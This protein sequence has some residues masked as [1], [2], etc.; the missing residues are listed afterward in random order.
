MVYKVDRLT[1]SLADFAK[2]IEVFD[3]QGASFVAVTQQFNTTSS[4]GRLTLNIL[5]SFAQFERKVTGE[6]IRDKIAASKRQGMWMGGLEPL[7]YKRQGR[8]VII[9]PEEAETVRTIFKLYNDLGFVRR[10]DARLC[11]LEIVSRRRMKADGQ[12]VGGVP[13]S[14]GS[15]YAM[16]SN[17]IYIGQIRHKNVCHAGLHEAIITPD[18]WEATQNLLARNR[19]GNKDRR[20]SSNGAPLLGKLFDENGERLVPT[21]TI[22]KGRRYRY[23]TSHFLLNPRGSVK[24][25]GLRLPAAAVETTVMSAIT[26][27]LQDHVSLATAWHH[28]GLPLEQ[29][30]TIISALAAKPILEPLG[31]VER[32]KSRQPGWQSRCRLNLSSRTFQHSRIGCRCQPGGADRRCGWCSITISDRSIPVC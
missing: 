26:S 5:L 30:R 18:L 28:A 31:I 4:M 29:Y 32:W 17:P 23:Y 6:R 20:T 14:K 11:K 3:R 19:L 1:R 16:L 12:T 21:Y 13:M 25:A 7:G 9:E 10:L 8:T 27:L 24:E 15:L 2:I 22:K